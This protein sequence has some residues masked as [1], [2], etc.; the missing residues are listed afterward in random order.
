[1]CLLT[2]KTR[3]IIAAIALFVSIGQTDSIVQLSVVPNVQYAPGAVRLK[4]Q[5]EP[6]KDNRY[7]CWGYN[8]D[9]AYRSSCEELHTGAPKVFWFVYS[10]V[11]AGDYKAF[12]QVFRVG[13]NLAGEAS[14]DFSV[15][16]S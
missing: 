13:D 11:P 6:H 7:F 9:E 8:S 10:G 4:I 15:I 1:M 14:R 12:V 3:L 5:I 16:G 2:L